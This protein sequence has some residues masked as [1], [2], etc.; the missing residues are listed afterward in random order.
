VPE[1]LSRA[2]T[3]VLF[4]FVVCFLG[5]AVPANA[6]PPPN[7]NFAD[8]TEITGLPAEA[9]GS[10]VDATR[11]PDEPVA[12]NGSIW[13][14]WTAPTDGGV[15]VVLGG[16]A[17]PFQDAVQATLSVAVFVRSPVFGLVP[18]QLTFHAETGRVYWIAIS[19]SFAGPPGPVP[20]PDICVRLLP[21]P[22]N[23]EFANATPL[24][25]FPVGANYE[26][27]S[28]LGPPTTEPSEP[29]HAG[30]QTNTGSVWYSWTAPVERPVVLRLCGAFAA[31]AVYTGD[32]VNE[33][34]WI[35]TRRGRPKACGGRGGAS[36]VFNASAGEAYRIAVAGP[37][38]FQLLIGTQLAVLAGRPPA[39]LY[40][41]F[42][43]QTDN[44]TLRLNGAGPDRALLVEAAGV[45]AA[46]GCDAGGS[47]AQLR[48]PIPGR[49]EFALD[50]DLGDAD[51]TADIDL[52]G[53]VRPSSGGFFA[54]RV[55]GGDGSDTLAGSAGAYRF[56]N[57]W[58]GGL[59]L[60]GGR[61][62]DRI[63]GG[64][65]YDVILGGPGADEINPGAGSDAVNS[66]SGADRVQSVDSSSDHIACH[67]GRD[68]ARLD[69]VDLA[70]KGCER[71]ELSSPAR[72]V[73]ISAVLSN[74]D[75]D[76]DDHLEI[77][78]ACP[79]DARRGCATKV[80][81]AVEP[82]RTITRRLH[83]R[84]GR[85]GMVKMYTFSERLL[86]RGVRVTAVTKRRRGGRL[87]VTRRLPVFDARYE[88]EG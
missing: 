6:A 79:L 39:V 17:P 77:S 21:G 14:K 54:R 52:L 88:G 64:G 31:V 28:E 33:L 5:V 76:D 4:A 83:V 32:R 42:P 44:L 78:V 62:R 74:D 18:V 51:D 81:A 67:S 46:N 20:D 63:L 72:A 9:T 57:G 41:A 47:G 53:P 60:S 8:A 23:D 34:H 10:N 15:T 65:G 40:T 38:S 80:V 68:E 45:P 19:S 1:R 48:C 70:G 22:P 56:D 69:G 37:S 85:S 43:G 13:F 61:G 84:R 27:S 75:G 3:P 12:G 50:V 35:V 25:G 29:D 86:S 55:S 73:P 26:S 87:T 58:T 11:E 16:C 36:V 59:S 66:G 30:D 71:R 7:D 2:T 49:T 82:H 24:S